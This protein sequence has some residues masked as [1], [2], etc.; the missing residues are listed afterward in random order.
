MGKVARDLLLGRATPLTEL[1]LVTRSLTPLP[2]WPLQARVLELSQRVLQKSDDRG[3]A[4]G[5]L[6]RLAL[7]LLQ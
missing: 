5:P 6:A 1:P 4:S 2:P 3:G 7:R